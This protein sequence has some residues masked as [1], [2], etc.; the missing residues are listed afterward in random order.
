[1]V[2]TPLSSPLPRYTQHQPFNAS[3]HYTQYTV[4]E[5]PDPCTC[6]DVHL[7][8][9]CTAA[10]IERLV[11]NKVGLGRLLVDED[12]AIVVLHSTFPTSFTAEPKKSLQRKCAK[13]EQPTA[14]IF[15]KTET[16]RTIILRLTAGTTVETLKH[17]IQHKEGIPMD[18]QRLVFAGRYLGDDAQTLSFSRVQKECTIH[19]ALR[20]TGC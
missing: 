20:L 12:D 4:P 8:K 7:T 9:S 5:D 13:G 19:M 1:M 10:D 11:R 14:Q 17:K 6:K 2:T 3:L 18:R 15:V 16:G